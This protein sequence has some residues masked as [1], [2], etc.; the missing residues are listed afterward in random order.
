MRA[1][2]PSDAAGCAAVY[3]PYV[4]DTAVSF[5]TEP[6]SAVDVAARIAGSHAWLVAE[7]AG[8]VVGYAYGTRHRER[9]AY[10]FAC[11]VSVYL[12]PGAT[13][14]GLGR[15]LYTALFPLLAAQ[16]LVTALA[17]VAL[18]NPASL[19][20]HR[21]LGFAEVGV[22]RGVGFKF[23]A[24]HDVL[25]LQRDLAPRSETGPPPNA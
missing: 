17:G 6:P 7:S 3:A 5:E 16:G 23:G 2:G 22:Y 10:R 24:W 1:A 15:R 25:W 20:L 18:P 11:D 4:R 21:S 9:A 14:H 13:G 12:A 8:S 19:A